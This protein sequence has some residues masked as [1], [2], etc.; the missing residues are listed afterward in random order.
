MTSLRLLAFAVPAAALFA[1][2][3]PEAPTAEGTYGVCGCGTAPTP[4][5]SLTLR[6]DGTFRYKN[7]EDPARPEEVSGTWRQEGRKLTLFDGTG[8]VVAHWSLDKQ[9]PCIRTRRGMLFTR[10]CRL[11]ACG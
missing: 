5:L 11:Q 3:P 6:P 7:G 4:D 8:A 9:G 10:L 2:T 1:F